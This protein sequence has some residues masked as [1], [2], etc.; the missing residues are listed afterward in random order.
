MKI[1]KYESFRNG[2]DILSTLFHF[3][4]SRIKFLRIE[5]NMKDK[6]SKNMVG[7]GQCMIKGKQHNFRKNKPLNEK[8]SLVYGGIVEVELDLFGACY[9]KQT[10]VLYLLHSS[11]I[12]S[13]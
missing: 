6:K 9:E 13:A 5:L 3:C 10:L 12:L 11:S 8:E 1:V 2:W 7:D 4:L